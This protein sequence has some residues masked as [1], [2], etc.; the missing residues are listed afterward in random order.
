[1]E[2]IEINFANPKDEKIEKI[3][4]CIKRGKIIIYPTDTIYGIG[5][6]ATNKKAVNK[7]YKIKKRDK[8][9]PFL[10]LIKSWFQL[11]KYFY[12]S[13]KQDEYLRKRWPGKVSVVL[14]PRK[15]LSKDFARGEEAVAV[16]LPKNDFLI[17]IL[18]KADVPMVSTS[19]NV[20]GKKSLKNV[21]NIVKYF[22]GEKPDLVIDIGRD[23]DGKPS[24]L[25][26]LTDMKNIKILRR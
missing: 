3:V 15:L 22:S 19:L 24:R 26:D 9:K 20:S 14:K 8:D 21:K 7:I 23:L 17:K 13:E 11:H 4:G 10:I 1:M 18:K 25:I 16:R 6:D 5:C 12:I 2:T